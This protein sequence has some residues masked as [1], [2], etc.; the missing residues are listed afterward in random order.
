M[1]GTPARAANRPAAGGAL[2]GAR[3]STTNPGPDL[4]GVVSITARTNGS[5]EI[6]NFIVPR[7]T[8]GYEIGEA[9][10]KMG[11]NASD[12]RPPSF[13]RWPRPGGDPARPAGPGGAERR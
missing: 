12:P 1:R 3:R 5:G 4:P 10:R 11:W 8:P 7:N 13:D 2:K 6:S 9:Y